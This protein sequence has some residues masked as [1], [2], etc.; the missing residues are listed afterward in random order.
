MGNNRRRERTKNN[1]RITHDQAVEELEER[2]KGNYQIIFKNATYFIPGSKKTIGELDL[3]GICGQDWDIYE[4]KT[5]E[6]QYKKAVEQLKRARNELSECGNIR[7]FYYVGRT[8]E[9]IEII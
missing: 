3:V 6:G 5:N 1:K 9:L 7:T 8:K 2:V 4:V